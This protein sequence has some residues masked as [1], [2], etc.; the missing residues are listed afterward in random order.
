MAMDEA[1]R[2]QACGIA[3]QLRGAGRS[4]DFVLEPKK[5]KW[6]FKQAE[7]CALWVA[8]PTALSAMLREFCIQGKQHR[9]KLQMN[10]PLVKSQ[11]PQLVVESP[12]RCGASRLILV[13]PDEW[14]KGTVRVKDL[15]TREEA[16]L[17][18]AELVTRR[19]GS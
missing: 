14:A 18:V 5:M 6:A 19:S 7:R 12:C 10:A 3:A 8:G 13:A 15:Q 4:V 16:D 11:P 1:L 2:P 17:P 9:H